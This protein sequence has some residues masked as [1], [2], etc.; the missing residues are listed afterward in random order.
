MATMRQY[1]NSAA[2]TVL[3]HLTYR[4]R[5]RLAP[6]FVHRTFLK[7]VLYKPFNFMGDSG[8]SPELP[9]YAIP[10]RLTALTKTAPGLSALIDRLGCGGLTPTK[11]F[12]RPD[13][14]VLKQM[15]SSNDPPNKGRR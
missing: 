5:A 15:A 3:N 12:S 9:T 2:A 6:D 14:N 11:P 10:G 1:G 13:E 7:T 8:L 4:P